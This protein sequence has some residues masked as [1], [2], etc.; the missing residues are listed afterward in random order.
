M[1]IIGAFSCNASIG[2]ERTD[3]E[4]P[5]DDEE[6]DCDDGVGPGPPD[7]LDG[8]AAAPVSQQYSGVLN[9]AA[10]LLTRRPGHGHGQHRKS[11]QSHQ[12]NHCSGKLPCSSNTYP[13]TGKSPATHP[14]PGAC[15][16][17]HVHSPGRL[18]H[19]V[20][21]HGSPQQHLQHSHEFVGIHAPLLL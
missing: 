18:P 13:H 10:L 11:D 19:R 16:P 14:P 7:L 6:L 2:E 3:E 1:N 15:H 17:P 12:H 21:C 9:S 4:Y 20:P 5:Y 8:C